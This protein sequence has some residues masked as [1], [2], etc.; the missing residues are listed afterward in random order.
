MKHLWIHGV[1]IYI[2]IYITWED[3]ENLSEYSQCLV[4]DL[5]AV[6]LNGLRRRQPVSLPP[7][8]RQATYVSRNTDA[9]LYDHCCSGNAISTY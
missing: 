7:V 2:Y 3:H 6:L 9:G 8:T 4:R 5:K 1:Y